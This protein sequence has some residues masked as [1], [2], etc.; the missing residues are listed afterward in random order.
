MDAV[1]SGQTLPC[2]DGAGDRSELHLE[3]AVGL[4]ASL[5]TGSVCWAWCVPSYSRQPGPVQIRE[6]QYAL[7]GASRG[8][9]RRG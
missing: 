2:E 9:H 8:T 7:L 5:T 6:S 4:L 3:E 1:V